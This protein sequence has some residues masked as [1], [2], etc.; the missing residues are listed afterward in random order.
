MA[1]CGLPGFP[2]RIY[3]RM[4]YIYIP[5]RL[6][7]RVECQCINQ[8]GPLKLK[9]DKVTRLFFLN[10]QAT[11]DSLKIERKLTKLAKGDIAI[12]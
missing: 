2:E 12:S 9:F 6:A 5:S 4:L 7:P 3:P 8:E 10:R 11:L 1:S